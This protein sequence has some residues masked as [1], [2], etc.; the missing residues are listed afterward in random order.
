MC[1]STQA[2]SLSLSAR[3]VS[4]AATTTA[5]PIA[6]KLYHPPREGGSKYEGLLLSLPFPLPPLVVT[7]RVSARDKDAPCESS[8]TACGVYAPSAVPRKIIVDSHV[9]SV[10]Y[11]FLFIVPSRTFQR[12]SPTPAAHSH[13]RVGALVFVLSGLPHDTAQRSLLALVL[14]VVVCRSYSLLEAF[15]SLIPSRSLAA[16]VLVSV[17]RCVTIRSSTIR[18]S[19]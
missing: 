6:S 19:S 3:P 13:S 5:H 11:P 1:Y 14:L 18:I 15:A 4:S 8:L 7:R 16:C 2:I 10:V 9:G 12:L 17:C